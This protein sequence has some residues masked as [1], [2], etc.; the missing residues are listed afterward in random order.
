MKGTVKFSVIFLG[1]QR[2]S[3]IV[4]L[5]IC[6]IHVLIVQYLLMYE[7]LDCI[8]FVVTLLVIPSPLFPCT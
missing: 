7:N 8:G 1:F 5:N 4:A 3:E 6:D 2:I